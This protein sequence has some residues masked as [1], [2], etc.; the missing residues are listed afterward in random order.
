MIRKTRWEK[1]KKEWNKYQQIKIKGE[2]KRDGE[3]EAND[4]K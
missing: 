4:K 3:R 2:R 1:I